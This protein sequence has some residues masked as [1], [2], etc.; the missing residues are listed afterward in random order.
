MARIWISDAVFMADVPPFAGSIAGLVGT[1]SM[2][3]EPKAVLMVSWPEAGSHSRPN[4]I[5]LPVGE[6]MV[7][8][9]LASLGSTTTSTVHPGAGVA[10]SPGLGVGRL[11]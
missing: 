11:S 2:L 5:C 1:I 7:L 8:F 4:M 3:G 6:V 10:T 9:Q